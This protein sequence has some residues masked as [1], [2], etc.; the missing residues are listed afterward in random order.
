MVD[1]P[2]VVGALTVPPAAAVD[3]DPELLVEHG[4]AGR[5]LDEGG[6]HEHHR[7]RRHETDGRDGDVHDAARTLGARRLGTGARRRWGRRARRAD[8]LDRPGGSHESGERK[9]RAVGWPAKAAVSSAAS[10]C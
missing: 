7:H 8:V 10:D 4:A 5:E 6:D 2:P 3:P 9:G 1:V